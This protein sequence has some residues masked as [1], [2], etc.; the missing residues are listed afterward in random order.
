MILIMPLPQ[1]LATTMTVMDRMASHQQEEAL[2][3][4]EGARDRPMRMIMGPVTTGGRKRMTFLTPTALMTAASTTYSRPA[5]TIP[6]QAYWSFSPASIA[7]YR[8]A[9]SL[10]MAW[11]P[12]R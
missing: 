9:S 1:M 12:P 2:V 11:K 6:P 4:A 8:P 10:A 3:T 5:T 7:A